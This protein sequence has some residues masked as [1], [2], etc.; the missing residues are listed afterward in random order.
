[1]TQKYLIKLTPHSYFFFGGER[2]F[3]DKA[4]YLVKSN[5]FPQQTALLGLIRYQLLRNSDCFNMEKNRI[6]SSK[7]ADVST[8]IGPNSFE[9]GNTFEFGKIKSL[10]PVFIARNQQG[11]VDYLFH[12]NNEYQINE[13]KEET[14]F[15]E[16]G[17]ME[18]PNEQ[19]FHLEK[20]SAK[21]GLNTF[22]QSQQS[23]ELVEPDKIFADRQQ[24]GIRKNYK[25]ET[26]DNAYYI[27]FFKRFQ[28]S[29]DRQ[30][31][32]AFVLE[33]DASVNHEILNQPK[34]V[35]GAEQCTFTMECSPFEEEFKDLIPDF[36][37][38]RNS[39]KVVLV[40]DAYV[41]EEDPLK[42]CDF[43]ITDTVDF[44]FLKTSVDTTE[45]YADMDRS[46]K[47]YAK[48][49]TKSEK[50]TLYKKGSVFYTNDTKQLEN[51]FKKDS[52]QNFQDLGYNQIKVITKRN[53]HENKQ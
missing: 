35:L 50:F 36:H 33:L 45:N 30:Y 16:I 6:I 2:T 18:T 27:Q 47:T 24:T 53:N 31:S 37:P 41:G 48:K 38:S 15:L 11:E 20:Y 12:A 34:V 42:F 14:E 4:N 28:N 51:L 13:K 9:V 32:F 21:F 46:L 5:D 49:V 43:A 10:S 7:N 17:R 23:S 52:F 25:G 19:F 29:A 8:L 1:M 44:R 22:Y 40:S 26:E 39:D 3:G